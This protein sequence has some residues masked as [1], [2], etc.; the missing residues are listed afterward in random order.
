MLNSV[1]DLKV[2]NWGLKAIKQI[3]KILICMKTVWTQT[4]G[5]NCPPWRTKPPTKTKKKKTTKLD[6]STLANLQKRQKLRPSKNFASKLWSKQQH[7]E[8]EVSHPPLKQHKGFLENHSD[9][10]S[11]YLESIGMRGCF[12][13]LT[14]YTKCRY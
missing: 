7:L 6:L 8:E 3:A 1:K 4:I 14:K 10:T 12:R 5:A 2:W 11:Y 9:L 13:G